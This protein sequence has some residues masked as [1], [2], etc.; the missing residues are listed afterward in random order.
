MPKQHKEK[1]PESRLT[2][3]K[4]K[5]DD[6]G[7]QNIELFFRRNEHAKRLKALK[8]IVN[9]Q[10]KAPI[11][12]IAIT[13]RHDREGRG[14]LY[15]HRSI[16]AAAKIPTGLLNRGEYSA[17]LKTQIER[18]QYQ[19][20]FG[21][22]LEGTVHKYPPLLSEYS[23]NYGLV[24]L[25]G[26][27]VTEFNSADYLERKQY[28]FAYIQKA[29][30]IGQPVLGICGGCWV[31]YQQYGGQIVSVAD[32]SYRAGMPRLSDAT[33]KIG[34][35]KQ[36]HR[37]AIKEDENLLRAALGLKPK[38][39]AFP[40]VN[41]VHSFAP[42]LKIIPDGLTITAISVQDDEL[43]PI[44]AKTTNQ[45]KEK[46]KPEANTIEAFESTHGAPVL[47]VQWHPEAYSGRGEDIPY[48]ENQSS[49]IKYMALAGQAFL[50]KRKL[51]EEFNANFP[52]I[53][54]TLHQTNLLSFNHTVIRQKQKDH[55]RFDLFKLK[56]TEDVRHI[57]EA[58]WEIM[59]KEIY[60]EEKRQFK[61]KK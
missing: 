55:F 49:L 27:S 61:S 4:K 35:N 22:Q 54:R 29:R 21:D 10:S 14:A 38:E 40:P 12:P 15:D 59:V 20:K 53:I 24:V 2:L 56:R 51:L 43:A 1:L 18:F 45:E 25:P 7:C 5:N 11:A 31:I 44:S 47:G 13:Y 9:V 3:K 52:K 60:C 17:H 28:E 50:W 19:M 32:H 34:N 33:G 6:A 41:S 57:D 46:I 39:S 48:S 58:K 16:Q 42:D 36:I 30:L 8:A 37:I 26:V 23:V